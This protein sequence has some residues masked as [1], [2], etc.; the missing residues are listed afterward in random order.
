MNSRYVPGDYEAR[1]NAPAWRDRA[2]FI[3]SADISSDPGQR[4]W[5][6]LW[7][8]RCNVGIFEICCIPFFVYGLALGDEVEV[9]ADNV[10]RRIV[11]RSGHTTFRVWF[12]QSSELRARD[13]VMRIVASGGLDHEWSSTNLLALDAPTEA[14]AESLAAEL[15]HLAKVGGVI[16]ESGESPQ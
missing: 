3:I 2:D 11:T 13:S 12:G 16:F 5:E 10:I 8:R 9:D 15:A 14:V 4:E 6:Q 7:A 1:H